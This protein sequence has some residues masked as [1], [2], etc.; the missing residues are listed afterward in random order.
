LGDLTGSIATLEEARAWS[1][2]HTTLELLALQC[3]A[4]VDSYVPRGRFDLAAAAHAEL[5]RTRAL[6]RPNEIEPL[7]SDL[8]GQIDRGLGRHQAARAAHEAG[9]AEARRQKDRIQE[10]YLLAA[11]AADHLAAGERE[12]AR[13]GA[14]SALDLGRSLAHPRIVFLAELT[15]A[16]L[17]ADH[18]AG[19]AAGADE[20]AC[21]KEIDDLRR[22]IE[23]HDEGPLRCVDRLD[24]HLA[25]GALALAAGDPR[26]A[27][28]AAGAGLAVADRGGFLEH[29]WRFRVLLARAQDQRGLPRTGTSPYHDAIRQIEAIASEI[30][31]TAMRDDY[32]KTPERAIADPPADAALT[33]N[34]AARPEPKESAWRMLST[35]FEITQVINSIHDP[36][37]LLNKVMDLAI[38]SVGAERGLIFLSP[39]DGGE[40]EPVVAR[41]VERQTIKDATAY[42]QGVLKEAGRGQAVLTHDA[43]HDARFKE[44]RSVV[45]FHIR[46]LMCVPL[47]LRGRTIG[48]VYVDTRAPRVVF[49][50]EHLK[51]L[52]AF[53]A[54]A[55]IAVDNAHLFDRVRK[56]NENLRQ[57]V[58]ERYGFENIVGRSAKMRDVFSILARVA[59]SPLPVMIRGESGTGKELVARAVHQNSPRRDKAFFSENCAALPDTLL[60]SELFG[61][62]RGA[63]TGAETSRKGLF[64]LADGG[65]LFLDEVGDMSMALQSKLLRALQDGEIRPL[66]AESTRKVNVRV[67][68]ATNRDL[69]GLIRSRQ[70][71][72]DLY[73]RLKGISVTLPPLR[74]RRDDIPLL[75]D[76]FLSRLARE[77]S[78][79]RLRV[80]PALLRELTR[81]EWPG[82]VRELENAIYRLSLFAEK[83]V[84][85]LDAARN[86]VD[87][88]EPTPSMAVRPV[89]GSISKVSIRKALTAAKGNRN[90]AARILGVSRATFFRK[91]R[92]LGVEAAR[93]GH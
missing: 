59:P 4:L 7:T 89:N 15:L 37:E 17:A 30:E 42:S 84:I 79:G 57:A 58:S 72:E 44:Y 41:N 50:P 82:N 40:M 63:F 47:S 76:H 21:A 93:K 5:V 83:G 27:A 28:R 87:S 55:A 19:A 22:R 86:D 53:A 61:H 25:I 73:Y 75:I 10:G 12:A 54:Q 71:R 33:R 92:E 38:E 43:E 90:Q 23:M 77:N 68:S 39:Q 56:E 24:R 78:Q 70:F 8:A 29:A 81:R 51:F 64:E 3:E 74:D 16:R 91:M 66:G 11:L 26:A 20:R 13:A 67:I 80:E 2:Q 31:D 32:L 18:P 14:L 62:V 69:E 65:T 85:T 36:D 35:L 46:S 52:E 1:R 48:T 49:T 9:L 88:A 6:I 60:E 45:R 34:A